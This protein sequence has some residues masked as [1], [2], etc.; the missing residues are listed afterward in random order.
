MPPARATASG[1]A[2]LHHKQPRQLS[3]TSVCQYVLAS[4]MQLSSDLTDAAFR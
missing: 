2:L 1:A 3:F 4:W